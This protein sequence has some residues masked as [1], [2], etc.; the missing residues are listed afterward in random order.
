MTRFQI[1]RD[2]LLTASPR[3]M[4]TRNTRHVS[5][6]HPTD[7]RV[8]GSLLLPGDS[9]PAPAGA[10]SYSEPEHVR[11]FRGI[12]IAVVLSLPFWLIVGLMLRG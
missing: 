1:R 10:V 3:R 9:F 11:A 7:R 8:A 12:L 4:M 6:T 5:Q 2:H